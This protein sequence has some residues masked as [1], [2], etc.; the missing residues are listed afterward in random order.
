MAQNLYAIEQA[1][2]QRQHR[3]WTA[4]NALVAAARRHELLERRTIRGMEVVDETS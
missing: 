1:Q 2:L 3:G 4:H